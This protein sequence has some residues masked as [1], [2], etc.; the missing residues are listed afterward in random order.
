[1]SASIEEMSASINQ[2]TENAKVT[3]G[4]ATRQLR[5]ASDGGQA[6]AATVETMKSIADK[7]SIIRC[8]R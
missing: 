1:M 4:I 6:V 2:N 5:K 8:W 3:D 7:I